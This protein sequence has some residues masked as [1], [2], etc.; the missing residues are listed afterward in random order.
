M[1]PDESFLSGLKAGRTEAFKTLV[2]I[3]EGPLFRFFYCNHRDFHKAEEQ[4]AEVLLEFT[5]NLHKMHGTVAQLPGFIFGIARN[6][7]LRHGHKSV[8]EQRTQVNTTEL[9]SLVDASDPVTAELEQRDEIEHVLKVVSAFEQPARD[10]LLFR[11]VEDYSLE[12]IADVLEMP[13]G[14]VKSQIHRG[15]AKLKQLLA[16]N[17]CDH[18]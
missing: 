14:S 5:R 6:I 12:Q 16:A 10:V 4:V 7:R 2:D 1:P 15:I 8:I 11:F 3:Y 18:E 17:T 9:K 13:L